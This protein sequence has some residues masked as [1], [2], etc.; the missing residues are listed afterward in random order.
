M[1]FQTKKI[2]PSKKISPKA[3]LIGMPWSF[4]ALWNEIIRTFPERPLQKREHIWASEL[5]GDPGTRYLK[6]HAHPYSNPPTERSRRKFIAGHLWEWIIQI[7]LTV[8]G[9]LTAKQ[10]KN[11]MELP[12]LLRVSGKLDFIVGGNIDWEKAKAE[13]KK[14]QSMFFVNE[15]D[16]PPIV[17]YA[18]DRIVYKMEMMFT[19]VPIREYIFEFKSV[20]SFMSEKLEKTGLAMPHHILQGGHYLLADRSIAQAMLVYMCKDDCMAH[21]YIIEPDKALVKLYTEDIK[22]M[23]EYFR[24]SGKN[25]IK[26]IPPKSP[27]ILFV[28]GSFTFIKN[29]FVEYSPY[30]TQLYGYKDF[31]NFKWKWQYRIS[32]WNRVFKRCVRE[33]NIT[34]AN[35]AIIKDALTEF[36]MWDKYVQQAK[37]AAAFKKP[38]QNEDE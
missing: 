30:L 6:M 22:M 28:E 3:Q 36:P 29:F 12:G 32:G 18:M 11:Q 10:V 14:M 38:D 13:I 23:T 27:E 37:K 17:T 4:A 33:E 20:S 35:K 34:P 9:I 26:N 21:E 16:I 1:A 19:R 24:S 7:I 31:D 5:G 25:Y 2:M 8:S 15:G